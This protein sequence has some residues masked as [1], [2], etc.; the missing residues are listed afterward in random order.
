M[1]P[2]KN[3]TICSPVERFSPHNETSTRSEGSSRAAVEAPMRAIV[4]ILPASG[5]DGI[6]PEVARRAD[7]R[8][9]SAE[10]AAVGFPAAPAT[11]AAIV[12][13][14]SETASPGSACWHHANHAT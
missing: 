12:A 6:T 10:A 14:C 13:A 7:W 9:A 5:T 1:T 8:T 2:K 4:R 3:H 11:M